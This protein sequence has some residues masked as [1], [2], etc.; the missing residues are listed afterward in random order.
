MKK[1]LVL[2]I[3]ATIFV[4]LLMTSFLFHL[5]FINYIRGGIGPVTDLEKEKAFGILNESLDLAGYEI[6]FLHSYNRGKNQFVQ[7]DLINGTSKKPCLVDLGRSKVL[8]K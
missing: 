8:K 5:F 3:L 7:V 2:W 4:V 6:E 1:S